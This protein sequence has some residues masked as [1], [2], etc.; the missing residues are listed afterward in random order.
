[1]NKM[2]NDLR[3]ARRS[4]LRIA[5]VAAAAAAMTSGGPALAKPKPE[6]VIEYGPAPDWDRFKELA[7]TAISAMLVDP[8]SAKFVWNHGYRKDGFTPF[9]SKRKYGYTTCG[10]VNAKNRMGGYTGA[11]TFTVVI[12]HDQVIYAEVGKPGHRDLLAAA[13]AK[14]VA[15]NKFPPVS[16]MRTA[17]A[18]SAL[19]GMSFASAS[20]GI[21]VTAIEKG[22]AAE[23]S[24][25]R[26]GMV[27]SHLNGIALKSLPHGTIVQLL[28]AAT[29]RVFT[30]AAGETLR[31]RQFQTA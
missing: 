30:T 7:E 13:C 26:T 1:M 10:Y 28:E 6:P 4:I 27:L 16:S 14:A 19:L 29:E 11:T 15:E 17:A 8:Y 25:F 12:D 23:A 2:H 24:G 5:A 3:Q 18:N 22:S 20:G 9:L 31:L 21:E